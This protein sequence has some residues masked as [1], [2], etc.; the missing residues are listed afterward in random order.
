[1]KTDLILPNDY[2]T[3][4]NCIEISSNRPSSY[5]KQIISEHFKNID[6]KKLKSKYSFSNC[7][8]PLDPKRTFLNLKIHFKDITKKYI[9]TSGKILSD[10]PVD[11]KNIVENCSK[12]NSIKS[13]ICNT[14][15]ITNTIEG[16]VLVSEYSGYTLEEILK[17]SNLT[18][19]IKKN[20]VDFAFDIF[21][22]LLNHNIC[23][24]GFAPRNICIYKRNS[25]YILVFIDL[26]E[27]EYL[28]NNKSFDGRFFKLNWFD[29]CLE[30][31]PKNAVFI[32]Q[33]YQR[34]FL[35]K[36]DSYDVLWRNLTGDTR[37]ELTSLDIFNQILKIEKQHKMYDGKILGRFLSDFCTTEFEISLY[38]WLLE[39]QETI[40]EETF[41]RT[42]S[43]IVEKMIISDV[44]SFYSNIS[45]LHSLY[46]SDLDAFLAYI[47]GVKNKNKENELLYLS[48]LYK[49]EAHIHLKSDI[50]DLII[51]ILVTYFAKD[52]NISILAR[53]TYGLK[54]LSVFSD[55][56]FEV[57]P[58]NKQNNTV[59][60]SLIKSLTLLGITCEGRYARPN[61]EDIYIDND[62]REFEEA[63]E[64][65]D[66]LESDPFKMLKNKLID[67]IDLQKDCFLSMKRPVNI[68][69]QSN[70][71][72]IKEI[73][74]AVRRLHRWHYFKENIYPE[75]FKNW[76]KN[77]DDENLQKA[78]LSILRMRNFFKKDIIHISLI[79][80]EDLD[81]IDIII[82][83]YFKCLKEGVQ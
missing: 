44:N 67:S 75:S 31:S 1:M 35:L 20:L 5:E 32:D 15:D 82:N 33:L 69:S 81:S 52:D 17:F 28:E 83:I 38:L 41:E 47:I 9:L 78:I 37:K 8:T 79:S 30:Y 13:T 49:S 73:L 62:S 34:T 36:E 42:L 72:N 71:I 54:L 77:L 76:V 57:Y 48:E 2:F 21:K 80:N 27:I 70:Y 61:E 12:N 65:R 25:T 51:K 11:F 39:I 56:D 14:I 24:Y 43:L 63:Y 74:K 50:A 10:I 60:I 4:D 26:E 19:K 45:F 29:I 22:E 3:I 59:E 7:I 6:L 23:W 46:I 53:G 58:H 40:N 16:I 64:L 55:L 18:K 68:Y 66:I